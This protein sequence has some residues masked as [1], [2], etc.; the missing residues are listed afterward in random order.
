MFKHRNIW[1]L[2]NSSF[3]IQTQFSQNQGVKVGT[4][5]RQNERNISYVR[6]AHT[7]LFGLCFM[8]VCLM[9]SNCYS[10]IH[11]F[12]FGYDTWK[13]GQYL[14]CYEQKTAKTLGGYFW[15]LKTNFE[16]S[17][18]KNGYSPMDSFS[19]LGKNQNPSWSFHGYQ[20]TALL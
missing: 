20:I 2:Q 3:P 14:G 6:L 8:S 4:L 12:F 17:K 9:K 16:D 10:L 18:G 15:P 11:I 7:S 5:G 13:L 19:F 1:T